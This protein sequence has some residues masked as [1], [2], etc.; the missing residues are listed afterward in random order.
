[1]FGIIPLIVVPVAVQAKIV[2]KFVEASAASFVDAGRSVSEALTHLR[3]IAA[4]GLENNRI[5]AFSELLVLPYTQEV[6]KGIVSGIGAGVAAGT[7]LFGAAFQYYIGGIFFEEGIVGF[8]DIMRVVLVLIF[9][10][11]GVNTVSKD[12]TDKAEATVAARRIHKLVNSEPSIDPLS[13][14][15]AAP[16]GRPAGKIEFVDVDFSYPA[17]KELQVY[18][19][20]SLTIESGQTVAL[21]GP[22][23]C[24]KST[25]VSLLERFYDVD[26]GKVLLDGV[27]I[28]SLK[29]SWLR[30]QIGLVSQEPVLFTG[31]VQWNIG[32]GLKSESANSDEAFEEIQAA[33]KR[34]N[35]HGFVS[36]FPDGY[37]TMVGERAV[38]LS[39]GQK[40]RLAIA[41]A[42]AR[43]PP[44][45]ILDE[46]TSA[47]DATSE[48]VVQA[49]LDELLKEQN[50]TTIMIAHRLSTIRDADKIVV[51]SNGAVVE[52]GPHDALLA[53][54]G[55]VY[56]ALVAHAEHGTKN[57]KDNEDE[58]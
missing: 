57:L 30:Q 4:L 9:M 26:A 20:L 11:F 48:R 8:N 10:A 35:A 25:L 45:L 33:A 39:G 47:L 23:G 12:A 44:I 21:A 43:N 51:F 29:V 24:G 34:A 50:R 55:G 42:I 27:D 28:C 32:L 2:A 1:V 22:S 13:S 38:Q 46:A 17:R 19:G 36:E 31:S 56:R 15:G 37:N 5:N 49:A 16:S 54:E 6:R 18:K 41:R 58:V 40:Q 7:I 14:T 53:K 52:E 3:T